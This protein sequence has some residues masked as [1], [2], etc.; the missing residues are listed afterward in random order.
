MIFKTKIKLI[1]QPF[2]VMKMGRQKYA[3]FNQRRA[4]K[5]LDFGGMGL[6]G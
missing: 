5:D 1:P 2:S 4:I 3:F 6:M